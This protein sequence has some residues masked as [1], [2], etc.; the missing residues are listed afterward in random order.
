MTPIDFSY[1]GVPISSNDPSRPAAYDPVPEPPVTGFM[2][3]GTEGV[4]PLNGGTEWMEPDGSTTVPPPEG[5]GSYPF[6]SMFALIGSGPE[7]AAK[8]LTGSKKVWP[9]Y[10]QGEEISFLF[11]TPAEG[12]Y[13]RLIIMDAYATNIAPLVSVEQA[14]AGTWVLSGTTTKDFLKSLYKYVVYDVTPDDAVV[15][16]GVYSSVSVRSSGLFHIT[17]ADGITE[18][19]TSTESAG[20]PSLDII[21]EEG[22]DWLGIIV[23]LQSEGVAVDIENDTFQAV[24]RTGSDD[25]ATTLFELDVAV[26]S[27]ADAQLLIN[28]P[29]SRLVDLPSV[30]G[31]WI[32]IWTRSTGQILHPARGSVLFVQS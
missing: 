18:S 28:C 3:S 31:W 9:T 21:L 15:D 32:L 17:Y 25:D 1:P 29:A 22:A 16:E 10:M 23:G 8:G 11:P 26:H 4:L 19:P 7:N 5:C 2:I 27:L 20:S 12:K 14:A 24:V 6:S 13:M 30:P